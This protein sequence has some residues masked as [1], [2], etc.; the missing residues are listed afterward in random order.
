MLAIAEIRGK[1]ARTWL[2]PNGGI[3]CQ[4]I[5][6]CGLLANVYRVQVRCDVDRCEWRECATIIVLVQRRQ[7]AQIPIRTVDVSVIIVNLRTS[8][9]KNE[10]EHFYS[11]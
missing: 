5:G 2:N 1:L 7:S 3:Q 10:S 8:K 11:R 4:M 6:V 9:M